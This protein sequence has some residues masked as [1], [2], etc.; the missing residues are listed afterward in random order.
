MFPRQGALTGCRR[1][2]PAP[3]TWNVTGYSSIPTLPDQYCNS[4]SRTS[5]ST[6][7]DID[8]HNCL[9]GK[10][11]RDGYAQ[12]RAKAHQA[13]FC[14]TNSIVFQTMPLTQLS[15]SQLV[16]AKP[17]LQSPCCS[18]Y[19]Y[20]QQQ[21]LINTQ[22]PRHSFKKKVINKNQ[23]SYDIQSIVFQFT[24]FI[25]YYRDINILIVY[26]SRYL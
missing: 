11:C 19:Y 8:I 16:I 21:K 2:T 25:F 5:S 23:K 20:H 7:K 9:G 6:H 18:Q 12:C 4:Y 26:F 14:A 24:V 22:E 1:Y 3:Q 15:A 13:N 10:H 17:M